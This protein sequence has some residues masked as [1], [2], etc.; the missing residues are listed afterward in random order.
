[1]NTNDGFRQALL[2]TA[3][4]TIQALNKENYAIWKDKMCSLLT[5][6]G[7]LEKLEMPSGTLD[8]KMNAEL[9][10][11]LI[12][13]ME[14]VTHSNVVNSAN[15]S[16]ARGLWRA[17]RER[18]ASS[19][20]SN[21]AVK[22][23][24]FLYIRFKEDGI[25]SF[26]TEIKIAIMKLVDIG[27]ELPEDILACLIL[28]KFPPEMQNLNQQIMHSDKHDVTFFCNHL[29]QHANENKAETREKQPPSKSAMVTLKSRSKF[30]NRGSQWVQG[31]HNPR[32]DSRHNAKECW[33]LHPELAPA[34]WSKGKSKWKDQREK[35]SEVAHHY[36]FITLE[37]TATVP[38]TSLILNSGASAHIFNNKYLFYDFKKESEEVIKTGKAGA[39]M[40]IK[41]QGS[42]S[43]HW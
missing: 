2:K 17:I 7:V 27:I 19:E 9:S 3:L 37:I 1:M 36:T 30:S 24:D 33:H 20:A 22:F 39:S 29:I 41:G 42:V 11:L 8:A 13:K 12:S 35:G 16:S 15:V 32:Q 31:F 18:F 5:M 23:N 25:K 34:W 14:P 4:D 6:H 43:L 28:F 10:M 38:T 40:A 21:R 26:V